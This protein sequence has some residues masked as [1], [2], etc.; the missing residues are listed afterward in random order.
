MR[1]QIK[2]SLILLGMMIFIIS[3]AL[4]F[5]KDGDKSRNSVVGDE[6]I[7]YTFEQIVVGKDDLAMLNPLDVAIAEDGTIYVTDSDQNRIQVFDKDGKFLFHFGGTDK[8]DDDHENTL[9]YPVSIS[10]DHNQ[11]VYIVDFLNQ[12]I[13]I[14]NKDGQYVDQINSE[15]IVDPTVVTVEDGFIY[16]F[17]KFDH[18]VKKFTANGELVL[19]F[20]T[21]GSGEGQFQYPFDIAVSEANNIFVSDSGNGRIQV[22]DEEGKYQYLVKSTNGMPSGIALDYENNIYIA[23]PISMEVVITTELGQRL[24]SISQVVQPDIQL[25]FP[26]G[27]EILNNHLYIVDKGNNHVVI[28]KIQ[29]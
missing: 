7:T 21:K 8:L 11:N 22:F 12:R 20:G 13:V 26:E 16:I 18:Q 10:L 19:A 17:D 4:F 15:K 27:I 3:I 2:T 6:N 14:Y 28:M 1:Q 9:N 29:K 5:M 25:S 23:D 24:S